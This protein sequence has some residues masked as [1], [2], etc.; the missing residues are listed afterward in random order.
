[1]SSRERWGVNKPYEPAPRS[2][3]G[4]RLRGA[5]DVLQTRTR[6]NTHAHVHLSKRRFRACPALESLLSA[7][8]VSRPTPCQQ[9]WVE[10]QRPW[11][12][13][14]DLPATPACAER[15]REQAGVRRG[16][17]G[18]ERW[19]GLKALCHLKPRV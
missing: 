14:A 2:R 13:P 12:L 6:R 17:R 5:G 11:S 1:M 9:G 4:R 15:L 19:V 8:C 18:C 16:R 7:F 10:P 3:E